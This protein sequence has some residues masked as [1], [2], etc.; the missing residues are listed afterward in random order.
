LSAKIS[1][2]TFHRNFAPWLGILL[3]FTALTGL[4][5]RFGRTWFGMAKETGWQVL[6]IHSGEW[7]GEVGSVFYVLVIG[8]GLIAFIVT[9]LVNRIGFKPGRSRIR[10]F[11]RI[12]ALTLCLPLLISATTGMAYKAGETWFGISDQTQNFLMMLHEGAWLGPTFK[13]FYVLLVGLG[14]L[15][16]VVSGW[17]IAWRK[18]A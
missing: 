12:F 2:R 18:K 4:I 14:L 3:A 17:R 1:F 13:P 16:V 6:D 11:H 8:L 9:G 15:A 7:L 10:K 5:Y